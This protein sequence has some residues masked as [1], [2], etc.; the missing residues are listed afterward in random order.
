MEIFLVNLLLKPSKVGDSGHG[1]WQRSCEV[2]GGQ[3]FLSL[4]IYS[5]F[6]LVVLGEDIVKKGK[7]SNI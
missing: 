7:S 6:Q 2:S 4:G 1:Q 5:H 3:H